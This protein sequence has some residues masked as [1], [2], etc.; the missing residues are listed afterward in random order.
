AR[1][2]RGGGVLHDRAARAAVA[3]GVFDLAIGIDDVLLHHHHRL[4][5]LHVVGVVGRVGQAVGHHHHPARQRRVVGPVLR[6][7]ELQARLAGAGAEGI[8]DLAAPLGLRVGGV[9]GARRV[10]Q[11]RDVVDAAVDRSALDLDDVRHRFG[12]AVGP[13]LRDLGERRARRVVGLEAGVR[14]RGGGRS[15]GRGRGVGQHEG[16]AAVARRD[17]D[18]RQGPVEQAPLRRD[19]ALRVGRAAGQA[20]GIGR[21]RG[22]VAGRGGGRRANVGQGL[23]A[24]EHRALRR[25]VGDDQRR[26]S[27][28]AVGGG[29]RQL[30]GADRE[31]AHQAEDAPLAV[32]LEG[33]GDIGAAEADLEA[34]PV[35][36]R[37]QHHLHERRS[38]A[39][40]VCARR[41]HLEARGRGGG[42][43]A[44]R[45]RQGKEG[46]AA[47]A[48][49]ASRG[50]QHE[51]RGYPWRHG[52]A[53]SRCHP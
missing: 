6:A 52:P 37:R 45:W 21:G 25:M 49:A 27:E 51:G 46:A 24:R 30:V 31:A 50:Q 41:Q 32:G 43:S 34:R 44:A 36:G 20:A 10:D 38:A 7:A 29:H 42:R 3:H 12:Q 8:D 16:T 47:S 39:D 4:G 18:G 22:G 5:V 48:A 26:R 35:R 33:T 15:G 14:G 1:V 40:H 9:P 23:D 28:G 17:R 2:D 53:L 11:H 19:R 13:G